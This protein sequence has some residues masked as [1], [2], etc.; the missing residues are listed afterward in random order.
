MATA[1]KSGWGESPPTERNARRGTGR[2]GPV[3]KVEVA[4]GVQ[5]R[6]P[7]RHFAN[8]RSEASGL[9]R[10]T[11]RRCSSNKEFA[12][13][14][15]LFALRH[16]RATVGAGHHLLDS[17]VAARRGVLRPPTPPSATLP[18]CRP[19]RQRPTQGAPH[20]E[21]ADQ[22]QDET[23]RLRTEGTPAGTNRSLAEASAARKPPPGFRRVWRNRSG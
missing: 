15:T 17:G 19:A 11:R 3:G 6:P 5:L 4:Q 18:S 14:R 10:R 22:E 8:S 9:H 2:P 23:R 20:V 7:I 1:M 21:Q 12:G 13:L 16:M